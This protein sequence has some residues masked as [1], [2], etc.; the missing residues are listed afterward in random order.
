MAKHATAGHEDLA[1]GHAIKH[2]T[3]LEVSYGAPIP[4]PSMVKGDYVAFGELAGSTATAKPLTPKR[5]IDFDDSVEDSLKN[6]PKG[7]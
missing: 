1:R 5:D 2:D 4:Q 6:Q 3:E 7:H